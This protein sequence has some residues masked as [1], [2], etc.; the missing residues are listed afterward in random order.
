[1]A[2]F[3]LAVPVLLGLLE[4][5]IAWLFYVRW[6]SRIAFRSPMVSLLL[7]LLAAAVILL[8]IVRARRKTA[9]PATPSGRKSL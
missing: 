5:A 7:L 3:L 4:R 2:L 6:L 8:V 9:A 1:M